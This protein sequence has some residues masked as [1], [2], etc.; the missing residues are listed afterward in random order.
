MNKFM[1][2]LDHLK[3]AINQLDLSLDTFADKDKE[4]RRNNRQIE[5]C[6]EV[7]KAIVNYYEYEN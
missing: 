7:L 4:I 6:I 3:E 2:Q 5:G 1:T